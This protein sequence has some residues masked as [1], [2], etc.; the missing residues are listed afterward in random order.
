MTAEEDK[1]SPG[2]RVAQ[3]P[4]EEVLVAY[5]ST[6]LPVLLRWQALPY[7]PGPGSRRNFD[8]SV[9]EEAEEIRDGGED[10]VANL[11]RYLSRGA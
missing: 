8:D 3:A 9:G 10:G 4:E 1:S 5:Q 7:P 11:K 2:L 6:R